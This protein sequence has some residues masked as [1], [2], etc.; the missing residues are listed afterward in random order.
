MKRLSPP[1]EQL[2]TLVGDDVTTDN[3]VSPPPKCSL[4]PLWSFHIMGLRCVATWERSEVRVECSVDAT[5][6][7]T[8]VDE[9]ADVGITGCRGG[10]LLPI[11]LGRGLDGLECIDVILVTVVVNSLRAA[12]DLVI[13]RE[14]EVMI[15]SMVVIAVDVVVKLEGVARELEL[16][17][18]G[19]GTLFGLWIF[20]AH[21]AVFGLELTDLEAV[22]V[23]G[24]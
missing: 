16:T 21:P 15:C 18:V 9:R 17:A 13:A 8:A 3:T 7:S 24:L 11:G 6:S 23:D 1:V 2:T 10:R 22:G 4:L 20:V 5:E 14:R 19:G 12:G